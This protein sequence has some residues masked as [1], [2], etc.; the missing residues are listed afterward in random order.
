M[1]SYI[2]NKS[3]KSLYVLKAVGAA[4]G[5]LFFLPHRAAGPEKIAG[6]T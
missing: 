2:L 1:Y 5:V 3:K 4:C 6:R